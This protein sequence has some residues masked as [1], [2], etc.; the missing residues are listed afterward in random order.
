MQARV[1][2][3]NVSAIF[4]TAHTDEEVGPMIGLPCHKHFEKSDMSIVQWDSTNG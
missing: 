2:V 3:E 1:T 4:V